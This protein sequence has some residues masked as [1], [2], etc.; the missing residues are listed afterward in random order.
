MQYRSQ[1]DP[2]QVITY[3]NNGPKKCFDY[4]RCYSSVNGLIRNYKLDYTIKRLTTYSQAFALSNDIKYAEAT[5]RILLK[6]ADRFPKY[7]VYCGHSISQYADCD[8]HYA[9]QHIPNLPVIDGKKCPIIVADPEYQPDTFFDDYGQT[10]RAGTTGSDGEYVE[11]MALAYDLVADA[12]RDEDGTPLFSEEEKKHVEEDL[13]IE[14]CLFGFFDKKINNKSTLNV[15]G[16][17]IVGLVVGNAILVRFG[18]D[19]FNRCFDEYFLKDGSTSQSVTYGL[20]TLMGFGG[21][22]LAFRNYS[23]P[24]YYTPGPDE[25]QYK[26]FNI[27]RDTEYESLWHSLTLL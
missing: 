15:K 9:V 4:Y 2:E 1:W 26:N 17:A 8:P 19:G 24:S 23:D 14:S 11:I 16:C 21:F 5:K 18:L 13:L 27:N 12:K 6:L 3:V 20:K 7:L 25:I 10:G 22:N